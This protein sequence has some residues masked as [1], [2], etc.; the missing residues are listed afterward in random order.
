MVY[1]QMTNLYLYKWWIMATVYIQHL[2]KNLEV[3]TID[4]FFGLQVLSIYCD[5]FWHTNRA[6]KNK[7]VGYCLGGGQCVKK[8]RI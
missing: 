4:Y 7:L 3:V 6:S 2:I 5:L 1:C 8:T